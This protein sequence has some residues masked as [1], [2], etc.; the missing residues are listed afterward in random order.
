MSQRECG[1]AASRAAVELTLLLPIRLLT[2]SVCE[3]AP[4]GQKP[5]FGLFL[6]VGLFVMVALITA[7][8]VSTAGSNRASKV[9]EA[10]LAGRAQMSCAAAPAYEADSFPRRSH[11]EHQCSIKCRTR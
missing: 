1:P 9:E 10:I 6:P 11:L 2:Y 3:T 8:Y 4:R 5:K 7:G